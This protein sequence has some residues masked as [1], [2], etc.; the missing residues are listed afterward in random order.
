MKLPP[1]VEIHGQ[2][3]PHMPS[4]ETSSTK[5]SSTS[6]VPATTLSRCSDIY[7]PPVSGL[8]SVTAIGSL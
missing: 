3:T 8:A 4:I 7:I 2:Y 5:A 6:S 1:G